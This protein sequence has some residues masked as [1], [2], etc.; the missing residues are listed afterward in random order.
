MNSRHPNPIGRVLAVVFALLLAVAACN[1]GA[2]ESPA[3]PGADASTSAPSASTT[4]PDGT[5]PTTTTS[6]NQFSSTTSSTTTTAPST[7]TSDAATT[8]STTT[9]TTLPPLEPPTFESVAGI[10]T[11]REFSGYTSRGIGRWER[12]VSGVEDIRIPS[13]A[14]GSE[15]PALWVPPRGDGDRP[16]LVILHSWSSNYL[17]HAG[18]PYAMWAEENGWAVIAPNFRGRNDDVESTGSE[19]AVQDVVDA[20][21]FGVAQDGVDSN[22][23]YAVGYSGGGM[24][25]LLIAGRHPDKVTA[26]AAWGPPYDLIDFYDESAATGRHY[27]GDL[28]RACGGDPRDGGAAEEECLR[29][30]PMTYLDAA[31]EQG[32]AVYI[33]QGFYDSLLSPS[34]GA[35]AFNQL[36]DPA[37]RLSEEEIEQIGRH[38][39]PDDLAG[40]V[41]AETHF[42]EGDPQPLFARQSARVWLVFFEADHEMVYQATMRWFASDPGL[43]E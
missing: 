30:S 8:S 9:T 3:G 43:A 17:Q 2:A 32:V 33:G 10:N 31:R 23:V 12:S 42:G 41:T 25:S 21:D 13:T 36:A 39:L 4:A 18:I 29:R 14:D 7:T 5:L 24:M 16:L 38:R 22:R 27:A 34:Q 26:V 6:P 40:S 15:Q 1:V 37:D 28:W 20:I 11:I 19:L 35:R